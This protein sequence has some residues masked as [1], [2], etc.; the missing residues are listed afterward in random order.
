MFLEFLIVYFGFVYNIG[1]KFGGVVKLVLIWCV[2]Y[3][4][5]DIDVVVFVKFVEFFDEGFGIDFCVKV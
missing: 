2:V 4:I 3:E 1:F 5:D